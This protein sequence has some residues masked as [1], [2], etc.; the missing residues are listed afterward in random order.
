MPKWI[1]FQETEPDPKRK[2]KV[3]I[4]KTTDPSHTSLG[5]VRWFGR[6]RAYSFFA[7]GDTVFERTCLRYLAEFCETETFKHRAAR[8][9]T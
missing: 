7:R 8:K 9:Q 5:S 3:W 4:V 1:E 6:W 2:T